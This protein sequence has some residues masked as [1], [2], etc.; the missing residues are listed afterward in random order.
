MIGSG[1]R[2]HLRIFAG[3]PNQ[4]VTVV[5]SLRTGLWWQ[6]LVPVLI[7]TLLWWYSPV[8]KKMPLTGNAV[9]AL[10][11]AVVPLWTGWYEISL[12]RHS[13]TDMLPEPDAFFAS[14]WSWLGA[15]AVFAFLLTLA[16]EALKDLEDMEGDRR[17][18]HRAIRP[19]GEVGTWMLPA[20]QLGAHLL[21]PARGQRHR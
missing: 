15:Y 6:V 13:Y 12:L 2:V 17:A 19:R 11:V 10:C 8:L 1:G 3:L 14:M 5:I 7:A 21:G 18:E 20:R 9:V 16:R 4:R